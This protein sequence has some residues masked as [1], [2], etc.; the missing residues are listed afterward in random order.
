MT[1]LSGI[2][3][4]GSITTQNGTKLTFKDLD[5]NGDG[6]VTEE[7]FKSVLESVETDSVDL[8]AGKG[9]E[10]KTLT[11]EQ[12]LDYTIDAQIQEALN[13]LMGQISK[14]FT[15]ANADLSSEMI[16]ALKE[17]AETF[18]AEYIGDTSK[19]VEEFNAQLPEKYEE[20]KSEILPSTQNPVKSEVLDDILEDIQNILSAAD[21]S[22]NVTKPII[23]TLGKKLE[24]LADKFISSYTGNN[25][26]ADLRSYLQSQ[27]TKSDSEKMTDA[28]ENYR[29]VY[30]NLGVYIDSGELNTLKNAVREFFGEA[31]D[32][33]LILRMNGVNVASEAAI[34]TLLKKYTD[35]EELNSDMELL[36]NSLSTDKMLQSAMN[37][38]KTASENLADTAFGTLT[39]DDVMIE[40]SLSS[41]DYSQIPGY[42]ENSTIKSSK[43]GFRGL[44]QAQDKAR[45]LLETSLKEQFRNQIA[46]NLQEKG[47]PFEKIETVFETVFTQASLNAVAACVDTNRGLI[48]WAKSSFNVQD[49]VNTFTDEFNEMISTTI[50]EMNASNT[51][52]DL[53]DIDYTKAL[54]R[55]DY[56]KYVDPALQEAFE[57]GE[58]LVSKVSFRN[59]SKYE[60]MAEDMINRLKSTMLSKSMAMCEANGVEFDNDAFNNVFN[61][62]QTIAI[63]NSTTT[64]QNSLWSGFRKTITFNPQDCLTTFTETFKNNY[65]VWVES[66]KQKV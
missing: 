16:A 50:N 26:K 63:M 2:N 18:K 20:L 54:V 42:Y 46:N 55:N 22:D 8:S 27:L 51:D 9:A 19:M 31:L 47:I 41:I 25:M 57:K 66:E 37:D 52:M 44:E 13:D 12:V 53:Q 34:E 7:E 14:D 17:F 61:N 3:Q 48:F 24:T 60:D 58:T 15:G 36:I 33:G 35:A 56:S 59:G 29:N 62:S 21:L 4:F 64:K 11:D 30:N 43:R 23:Q 10:D 1:D 38:A 65:T 49:L 28:I 40:R 5:L 45:D 32:N 39:G 6:E